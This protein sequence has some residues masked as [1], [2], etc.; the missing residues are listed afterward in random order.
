MS[1]GTI[2]ISGNT[3]S[4][5][6]SSDVII[7]AGVDASGTLIINA[8]D[9]SFNLPGSNNGSLYLPG[10]TYMNFDYGPSGSPAGS[11]NMN[12]TQLGL[13]IPGDTNWCTFTYEANGQDYYTQFSVS[14]FLKIVTPVIELNSPAIEFATNGNGIINISPGFLS[15]SFGSY[16][17]IDGSNNLC[18]LTNPYP[19]SQRYKE[20]IISLPEDR[21]NTETF[22]KLRPVQ[23]NYIKDEKKI[24]W[25]GFIAEEFDEL[26]LNELV[27]Y[28]KEGQPDSIHCE[29]TTSFIVKIVQEQQK[30]IKSQ[31][32]EIDGL[33]EDIKNLTS[34]VQ[35][36]LNSKP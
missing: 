4:S 1:A 26:N 34:L 15:S 13:Y 22:E 23:F 25:I 9:V 7:N 16:L 10:N 11:I 6:T 5:S 29:N 35:G 18:T 20:N 8:T 27:V 28:N 3:I 24:K 2:S 19:S 21:Y 33:K 17:G 31:Q 14:N 32:L 30:Q 36:L 12:L